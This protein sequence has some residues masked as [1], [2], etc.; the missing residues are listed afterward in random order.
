[1]IRKIIILAA[2]LALNGHAYA[3]D[4]CID[5]NYIKFTSLFYVAVSKQQLLNE[6]DKRLRDDNS[7]LLD[8]YNKYN[9]LTGYGEK[10]GS[11]FRLAFKPCSKDEW[12][13]VSMD[14]KVS[15][16]NRAFKLSNDEFN[17]IVSEASAWK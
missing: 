6:A 13:F 5:V 2:S 15:I 4:N 1:M 16:S 10:E 12:A 9:E 7:Y 11:D 14:E 17:R 8:L 3:G